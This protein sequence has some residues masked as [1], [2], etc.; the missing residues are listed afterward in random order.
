MRGRSHAGSIKLWLYAA[1]SV[2]LAA[3]ITPLVF[4]AGQALVEVSSDKLTN[5]L[6]ERLA[7]YFRRTDFSD[8]FGMTL[9]FCA[10]L[11]FFPWMEW[12]QVRPETPVP[13][14]MGP[15]RVRLPWNARGGSGGQRLRRNLLGP[16]QAF[17][18]F[19]IMAGLLVPMG[20]ALVPAGYL[21]MK[22]PADGIATA[23]LGI[24]VV[25]A[26][27]AALM[28]W[29]FRGVSMGVFLRSMRPAAAIGMS[30]FF[31]TVV[32]AVLPTDSAQVGDPEASGAGF[33]L[34]K[35]HLI[36]FSDPT[37]LW[38]FIVPTLALGLLLAYARWRTASLWL[39]VGLH[40]GW[41]ASA[42]ALD[43]L[44]SAPIGI[45]ARMAAD[46]IA[47]LTATFAAA[48]IVHLITTRQHEEESADI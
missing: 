14:T 7:A 19:L 35:L 11:L 8:C 21:T 9:I 22:T 5:G 27:P 12:I 26:I 45:P 43:L 24:A 39:A 13:G 20:M 33:E 4:N 38:T 10:V 17:A 48:I 30:A 41:L 18:G 37:N 40:G 2:T 28:E 15:W 16:W 3:W 23:F 32:L 36:R 31:F 47:P 1:A 34:L 29:M 46:C 42:S 6:L 25:A 44:S